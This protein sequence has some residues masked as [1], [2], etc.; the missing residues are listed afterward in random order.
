MK[1]GK[2]LPILVNARFGYHQKGNNLY[3]LGG[4]AWV[5]NICID[6]TIPSAFLHQHRDKNLRVMMEFCCSK[7]L[8]LE[9]TILSLYPRSTTYY[10]EHHLYSQALISSIYSMCSLV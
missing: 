1:A 8:A 10:W 3:F 7:S 2:D 5:Y 4:E 6:R 9:Q